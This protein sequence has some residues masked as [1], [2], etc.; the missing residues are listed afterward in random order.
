RTATKRSMAI[1]IRYGCTSDAVPPTT[2][3]ASA[4]STCRQYGHKYV[5]RR[6]IRRA[7][8]AFPTTSSSCSLIWL[9]VAGYLLLVGGRWPAIATSNSH[10]E[11]ATRNQLPEYCNLFPHVAVQHEH[12][13]RW[14]DHGRRQ[15]R[16]PAGDPRLDGSPDAAGDGPA[17]R[18]RHRAADR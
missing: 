18:V 14:E 3:A 9:L 4:T 5:S 15:I 2:I 1:L 10:Q 12:G 7:S 6:R 8:Y 17:A 11:P 13:H 16:H